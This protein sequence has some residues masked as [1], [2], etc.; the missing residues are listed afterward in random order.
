[1]GRHASWACG[2][3]WAKADRLFYSFS[4]KPELAPLGL[5][6]VWDRSW[7]PGQAVRIRAK[8]VRSS[9]MGAS[10]PNSPAAFRMEEQSA[11]A[12][13]GWQGSEKALDPFQAEFLA[14]MSAVGFALTGLHGK[15]AAEWRLLQTDRGSICGGVGEKS[16]REA[17]GAEFGDA[18]AVAEKAGS[19]S[20]IGVAERAELLV[21]AGHKGG[22]GANSAGG[23]NDGAID[24]KAELSHGVGF[25][26]IRASEEFG[27]ESAEDLLRGIENL[28]VVLA[29][30]GDVEHT[31]ENPSGLTRIES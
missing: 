20:R 1:M 23:F 22:T 31:H 12:T 17:S 11:W 10:A 13:R 29:A 26:D 18:I 9:Q 24:A 8:A 7:P 19:V 30:A 4:A 21:V 5:T 25:V 14:G 15:R 6:L 27:S 16:Q 2:Q 3:R 28:A